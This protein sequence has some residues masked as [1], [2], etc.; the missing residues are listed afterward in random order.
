MEIICSHA[1]ENGLTLI[2]IA[3]EYGR[4]DRSLTNEQLVEFYKKFGFDIDTDSGIKLP[5]SMTRYPKREE[6]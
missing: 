4:F 6:K 3:Q 2:L 1:D 5:P